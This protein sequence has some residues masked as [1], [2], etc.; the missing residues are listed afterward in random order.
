MG[1]VHGFVKQPKLIDFLTVRQKTEFLL[2][3][4][5]ACHKDLSFFIKISIT[6][7]G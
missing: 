7:D 2:L 4:F 3:F 6:I 1:K 5:I